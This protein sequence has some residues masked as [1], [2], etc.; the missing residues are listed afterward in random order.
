VYFRS[1]RDL[2]WLRLVRARQSVRLET[3]QQRL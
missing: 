3:V 1:Q 2:C